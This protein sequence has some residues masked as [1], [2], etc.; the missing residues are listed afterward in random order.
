M[1]RASVACRNSYRT[2]ASRITIVC[3]NTRDDSKLALR[4]YSSPPLSTRFSRPFV[5]NVSLTPNSPRS[6]HSF[7]YRDNG[8]LASFIESKKSLRSVKCRGY[9]VERRRERIKSQFEP[10]EKYKRLHWLAAIPPKDGY[11]S[12]KLS[13]SRIL[14]FPCHR[15]SFS[16]RPF[17]RHLC[18]SLSLKIRRFPYIY[19][20]S[21]L[22]L[23]S[24]SKISLHFW[25]G[26]I[27][28]LL[29]SSRS[30]SWR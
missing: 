1:R 19:I 25:K 9:S 7:Y 26:K 3:R 21:R 11:S 8:D 18:I 20:Y 28:C 14:A 12:G 10:D 16:L 5:I 2:F 29:Y 4:I 30:N 23:R 17:L 22:Y 13:F 6:P 15:K 24:K 27:Y